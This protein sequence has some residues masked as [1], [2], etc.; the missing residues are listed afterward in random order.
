MRLK[1]GDY[2]IP[3]DL[4]CMKQRASSPSGHRY[5]LAP[6]KGK[7]AEVIT[8][9]NARAVG[10]GIPRQSLQ[11][12]SWNIQG[13]MKYEE[14]S[15]ENRQMVD[16]LLPDY[17][18]RLSRSLLEEIEITYNQLAG[19]AGLPSLN[20]AL[21]RLGDVGKTINSFRQ[22]RS[23][24]IRHGDDYSSLARLFITPGNSNARGGSAN[25]PW[26][27]ISDRIYG[28]MVT[29][30]NVSSPGE[31]QLRVLPTSTS[32]VEINITSL[33]AEPQNSN[34][35][36]LTASPKPPTNTSEVEEEEPV[37]ILA[38]DAESIR[39]INVE[40]GET[41][42]NF[43]DLTKHHHFI[44]DR[45]NY[46]YLSNGSRVM[47][48]DVF[49]LGYANGVIE[50][51]NSQGD[52]VELMGIEGIINPTNVYSFG[53][54]SIS[55]LWNL[56]VES[57]EFLDLRNSLGRSQ[58]TEIRNIVIPPGG[59][60][61]LTKTGEYAFRYNAATAVLNLFFEQGLPKI[62]EN[63][64]SVKTRLISNIMI[65]VTQKKI[66]NLVQD[67]A[68]ITVDDT[69]RALISTSWIEK[70]TWSELVKIGH[71]ALAEE[72]TGEYLK[73]EIT[74]QALEEAQN[75]ATKSVSW[76]IEAAEGFDRGG[77]LFLQWLNFSSAQRLETKIT[78]IIIEN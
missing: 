50:V 46:K 19:V 43:K 68:F 41:T 6:L 56:K 7:M 42:K 27:K 47:S 36:P 15:S 74:N 24:L 40:P 71:E 70:G 3:V 75:L 12:L 31:I 39:G 37:P 26:S 18:R 9:L 72:I 64:R 77:N 22:V 10:T 66:G 49:N 20:S 62:F 57:Y 5:L 23:D 55:R 73:Q 54:E 14:M 21:G 11:V 59:T 52:L 60:L 16:R 30:G 32:P 63:K 76:W 33:V 53:I 48:F 51:R 28:R 17:K 35:Q 45:V 65:K 61:K 34:I 13:G 78:P 44:V 29:E 67:G 69:L 4:F 2:N 1:P 38:G 25:T 8:A 58:K